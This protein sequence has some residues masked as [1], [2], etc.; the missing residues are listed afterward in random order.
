MGAT[1]LEL[2][3]V[4]VSV[5][6][7]GET[8]DAKVTLTVPLKIPVLAGVKLTLMEQLPPTEIEPQ[9]LVWEKSEGLAPCMVIAETRI[10]FAP[11]FERVKIWAGLVVPTVWFP[12]LK[13]AGVKLAT[14][15]VPVRLTSC[16]L[17]ATLSATAIVPLIVP[18]A[19]GVKVTEIVQLAPAA[20]LAGQVLVSE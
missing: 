5:A 13:L 15:H 4:P 2:V 11:T 10:V 9:L 14:V 1:L 19:A 17:P 3:P 12:K 20:R 8:D 7:T 16:G 18:F 6:G